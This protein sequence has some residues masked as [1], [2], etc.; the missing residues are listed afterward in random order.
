VQ[1]A[2]RFAGR[3][4]S[5]ELGYPAQIFRVKFRVAQ[6]L[7]LGVNALSCILLNTKKAAEVTGTLCTAA[8]RAIFRSSVRLAGSAL[9]TGL[10]NLARHL[11]GFTDAIFSDESFFENAFQYFPRATKLLSL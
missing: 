8:Q 9:S 4:A 11:L 6:A 3:Y 10:A 5:F 2:S 1:L 7:D